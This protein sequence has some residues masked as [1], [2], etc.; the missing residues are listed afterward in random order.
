MTPDV[1][2]DVGNSRAK[3]GR[4][5]GGAVRHV[6]ALPTDRPDAWLAQFQQWQLGAA[7][8]WVVGGVN[9]RRVEALVAWLREHCGGVEVIGSYAQLPLVVDVSEPAAVGID[10]L[11]NAVAAVRGGKR[12]RLPAVVIDA[13]TAVTVDWVDAE[14]R[15]RGG[16]IFPGLRLM[17]QALCDH[18]ALLPFVAVTEPRP[19]LPGLN[20]RQAIRGGLYYAVAG[21]INT[22]I[23]RLSADSAAHVFLTGGDA[24]LLRE[25][26]DG[27]AELWPEMTLE[28]LRLTAEALT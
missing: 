2:V 19:R 21:G 5:G 14:G 13:G 23:T 17:A 12:Q 6:A 28:G 15:F 9:P 8:A 27:R 3:W 16:T 4:C 26:I 20:T 18:T 11:L 7:T 25:A 1:V 22:L 24:A 10:R